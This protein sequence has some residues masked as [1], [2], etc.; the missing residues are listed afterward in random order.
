MSAEFDGTGL[1]DRDVP[2]LRTENTLIGAEK[3]VDH[4]SV[5]LG[6]AHEEIDS[7]VW[8]TASYLWRAAH[9]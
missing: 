3:S 2:G 1:M 5:C 7:R 6:A 8:S 9:S 4:G